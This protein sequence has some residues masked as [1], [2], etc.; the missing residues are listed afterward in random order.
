M[1]Y[2]SAMEREPSLNQSMKAEKSRKLILLFPTFLLSM[3]FIEERHTG[4]S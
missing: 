4:H 3:I 1:L 2:V